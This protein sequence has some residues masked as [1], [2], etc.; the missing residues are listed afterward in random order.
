MSGKTVA[1]IVGM[2]IDEVDKKLTNK[3]EEAE[4]Q[5]EQLSNRMDEVEK[6]NK[7]VG[8]GI[9]GLDDELNRKSFN[10]AKMI[11]GMVFERIDPDKAW[12]GAGYE[13]QIVIEGTKKAL[14]EGVDTAGGYLVPV[15]VLQKEFIE[16]LRSKLV[17]DQLGVRMMPGLS[18]APVEIPGQSGGATAFWV[19]ENEA[20]TA[21][22][23]AFD[24]KSMY[25]KRAGALVKVSNRLLATASEAMNNLI[26]EDLSAVMARHLENGVLFGTSGKQPRGLIN[27]PDINSFAIGTNGGVLDFD[28]IDNM[29]G[30][31]EDADADTLGEIKILMHNKVKR[32]LKQLKVS[33]FSTQTS[34]QGYLLGRPPV[35]DAALEDTLGYKFATTNQ[36]PTNLTKGSGTGLSHVFVGAWSELVVGWWRNM[37]FKTSN[38]AGDASGSAFTQ[39]Q[40][41]V[42]AEME[43]DSL[44]RQEKAI[45]LCSDAKAV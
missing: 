13:K 29:V 30:Q 33:Y 10:F 21:S 41:W 11:R 44:L 28:S 32:R 15:E 9:S 12:E 14:S 37:I 20:I 43:L 7:R 22:Q 40:T 24:M 18:G 27:T 38:I 23:Q 25:P 45:S 39:N 26:R 2:K 6:T 31:L 19:G 5:R 35:S 42:L 17:F 1:D 34:E 36:I 16:L 4:R 8:I 3:F